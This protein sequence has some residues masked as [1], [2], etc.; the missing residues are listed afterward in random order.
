M[1]CIYI[2]I[3]F[4]HENKDILPLSQEP[5][6]ILLEKILPALGMHDVN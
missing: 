2:Y 4:I 5:N 3:C 6:F 1:C